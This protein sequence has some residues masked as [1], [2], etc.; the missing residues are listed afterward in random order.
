MITDMGERTIL[1]NGKQQ[2]FYLYKV[3]YS[4]DDDTKYLGIA[5]PYSTNKKDMFSTHDLTGI[6]WEK[7]FDSKKIDEFLK[8]YLASFEE[9]KETASEDG[10]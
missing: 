3:P 5:G 7:E 6:Y 2:R 4:V 10:N 1:F 8:E 9:R